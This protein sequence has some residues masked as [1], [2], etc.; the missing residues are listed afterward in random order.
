MKNDANL[1]SKNWK[2]KNFPD[3]LVRDT[4]PR[5]SVPKYRI[6][7]TVFPFLFTLSFGMHSRMISGVKVRIVYEYLPARHVKGVEEVGNPLDGAGD[8]LNV[9][10]VHPI[11]LD[12]KRIPSCWACPKAT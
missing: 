9:L 6:R 11:R 12:R 5:I 2:Q 4:D 7:N 3:L 8:E 10:S 1:P